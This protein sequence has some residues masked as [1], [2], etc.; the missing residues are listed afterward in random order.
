MMLIQRALL[1]LPVLC[2][3][4]VAVAFPQ[5]GGPARYLRE[6]RSASPPLMPWQRSVDDALALSRAT[7]KPLLLCVNMDGELASEALAADRYRDPEFVALVDGFIPLL[8]SPDRHDALDYTSRGVRIPDSKFGRVTN[9]EHVNIETELYERWFDGRRV[10]PRHIGVSPDGEVLFDLYLLTDLSQIDEALAAHGKFDEPPV[11]ADEEAQ[12]EDTDETTDPAADGA[13]PTPEAEQPEEEPVELDDAALLESPDAAHRDLLE[14][15]F[16]A[17]DV[18]TRA[19]LARAALLSTRDTQHPELLRLAL[20]DPDPAV[21]SAGLVALDEHPGAASID[22]YVIAARVVGDASSA[23]RDALLTALERFAAE[24]AEHAALSAMQLARALRAI[25]AGS[26]VVDVDAWLLGTAGRVVI[27]PDPTVAW[28]ERLARIEERLADDPDDAD[29][30]VLFARNG[31]EYAKQQMAAGENPT[32]VLEDVRRAARRALDVRPDDG[33]ANA[34]YAWASYMQSDFDAAAEAARR[35]ARELEAW[36]A[37]PLAFET[38]EVLADACTRGVYAQ[39]AENTALSSTLLADS[40]A[41]HAVLLE[42]PLGTETQAMRGFQLLGTT[43]LHAAQRRAVRTALERWPNSGSM[44][45]WYRWVVMRDE[46]PDGLLEAY[47]GLTLEGLDAAERL[48]FAG[49]AKL[50]AAER[51]IEE[52]DALRALDDYRMAFQDFEEAVGGSAS[53]ATFARWYQAQARAGRARL[54]LEA[55]RLDEAL[56]EVLLG[57]TFETAAHD[58]PDA[59]GATPRET[60]RAVREALLDAGR[61]SDAQALER[62]VDRPGTEDAA[63]DE[64]SDAES[65]S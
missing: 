24:S 50:R 48:S 21:R 19:R 33:L 60:L 43:R 47:E 26:E 41:A 37:T 29:W 59:R 39:L 11:A 54:Y 34:L 58:E 22:L 49:L 53:V 64:A 28:G 31:R 32:F 3:A 44:H 12:G 52:R 51:R 38:I 40:I 5:G 55:D 18:E 16:V 61:E 27:E 15:R 9:S 56:A 62:F 17:A 6:D 30:N 57:F 23:E 20:L 14:A 65:D 63:E 2:L 35:A 8:A 10:A 1:S 45:E 4:L 46:G 36:S 13:D 25:G 42:H 7:G